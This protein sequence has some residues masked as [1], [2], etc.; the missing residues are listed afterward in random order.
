MTISSTT[1]EVTLVFP[2]SLGAGG[3]TGVGEEAAAGAAFSPRM[4]ALTL[5]IKSVVGTTM[6][7]PALCP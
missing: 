7:C 2:G 3:G 4:V 6:G 5:R 1:T